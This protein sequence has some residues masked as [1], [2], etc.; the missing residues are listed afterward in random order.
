M[1]W[2]QFKAVVDELLAVERR[3]LGVQPFIDRQIRLGLGEVQRL[4]PYYATGITTTYELDDVARDG[5]ASK[6]ELPKGASLREMYH[7][8]M[9]R[10]WARRPLIEYPFSNKD[11]LRAGVVNLYGTRPH[12]R[13]A[14]DPRD[15]G[16]TMWVYPYLT[17]GY[18]VKVLWDAI[19][20]RTTHEYEDTDEVPF[21]EP[22]A[23]LVYEY[24]KKQLAKE[25]DRDLPLSREHEREFKR[26]LSLLYAEVQDRL[27]LKHA[28]S[29]ASDDCPSTVPPCSVSNCGSGGLVTVA[30]DAAV[31]GSNCPTIALPQ[32]EWAMVGD[33]G[34]RAY[35]SDTIAVA[36]AIKALDPQ[37]VFHL[38]DATYGGT[39]RPAESGISTAA[40]NAAG[41]APHLL[42][43]L[44]V[45]HYWSFW[46]CRMYWVPGNHDLETLYGAPTLNALPN[47]KSLIGA[48]RLAAN[49]LWYSFGRGPVRFIALN[50]GTADGDANIQMVDM[51]AFVAAEVAAASEPWII[52]IFHRPAFTSDANHH[53]G[54][55]LMQTL[56]N[57]LAELGVDLVVN[58]HAHSYERILDGTG[59]MHV[60]CGLGGAQKRGA[61]A[62]GFP[63]GSQMFYSDKNGFLHF[64][65]DDLTLQ[66][67]LRTVD[68][69]VIDRVT[70]R[71]TDNIVCDELDEPASSGSCE[72]I[73]MYCCG[74]TAQSQVMTGSGHPSVKPYNQNAPAVYYADNGDVYGWNLTTK[75]WVLLATSSGAGAAGFYV[76]DNFAAMRAIAPLVANKLCITRGLTTVGDNQGRTYY[77][78]PTSTAADDGISVAKP[79]ASGGSDPGRWIQL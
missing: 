5:F 47:V 33:S 6:L 26:Q 78:N 62:S 56:T 20:G 67:E 73:S 50:S 41:G 58:G 79:N 19:V 61:A 59:L 18:A 38:G 77:W 1:T 9:G 45:K 32:L 64:K 3:R 72:D 70:L 10:L 13:Y 49:K 7:V 60:V 17:K 24:V 75:T 46:D 37:F 14:I 27:R 8:K 35:L 11:D 25:V 15:A 57:D 21:D 65:A 53:P 63:D 2:S 42:T 69:E 29:E 51:K 71:K 54:S 22:V 39:Q 76:V 12:F 55:A 23:A 44:F 36:S 16:R 30:A 28:Q 74:I 52:V 31:Y 34:Q 66:W 43:D 4:L 48:T 40:N 68:N